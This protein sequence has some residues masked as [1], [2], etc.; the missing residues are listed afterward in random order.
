MSYHLIA[1]ETAVAVEAYLLR[2]ATQGTLDPEAERAE[3]EALIRTALRPHGPLV[4]AW[5]LEDG[6]LGVQIR[7]MHSS[8]LKVDNG[9]RIVNPEALP[10][11]LLFTL[12]RGS[13]FHIKDTTGERERELAPGQHRSHYVYLLND[14]HRLE[15]VLTG[16]GIGEEVKLGPA[17]RDLRLENLTLR[18]SASRTWKTRED[19]I[20]AALGFRETAIAQG[21]SSLGL[22]AIAYEAVLRVSL[23]LLDDT[24]G[25]KLE[26]GAATTLQRG[27]GIGRTEQWQSTHPAPLPR[28]RSSLA[29]VSPGAAPLWQT[30][31]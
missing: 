3:L 19:A 16:A 11:M 20:E 14:Q 12:F 27:S 21:T 4:K 22:T 9:E 6:G 17:H 18:P 23:K 25:H 26:E 2:R 8:L 13:H 31:P 28:T 10:A 24:H 30:V 29:L 5:F 7:G 15:R 1:P